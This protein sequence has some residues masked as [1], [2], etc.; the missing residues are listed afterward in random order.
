MAGNSRLFNH[1]SGLWRTVSAAFDVMGLSFVWM[2]CCI[3]VVTIGPASAALYRA[4]S[5]CTR[6]MQPGAWRT[7]ADSFRKNLKIGIGAGLSVTVLLALA[8]WSFWITWQMTLLH[9]AMGGLLLTADGVACLLLTG[10]LG[11]VFPTLAYYEY[12]LGELFRTCFLLAVAHLP[13]TILI[14]V[15]LLAAG[16]ALI[17]VWTLC[18]LVP[19]ITVLLL[20]PIF[21]S[22][23]RK[24]TETEP[25]E[26]SGS[27]E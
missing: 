12:K 26:S 14:S 21:E 8:A 7:Y 9:G 15:I 16:Y 22:I 10:I 2:V 18:I 19:G 13:R 17:R 11:Y 24:H 23:F 25:E 3:P 6:K 4:L 5:S 1:E 20:A 27:A